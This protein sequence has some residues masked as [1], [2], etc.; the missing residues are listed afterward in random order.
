M[1]YLLWASIFAAQGTNEISGYSF[2]QMIFYYLIVSFVGRIIRGAENFEVSTDIYEGTLTR[3]LLFPHNYLQFKY[4]NHLA[5]TSIGLVQAATVLIILQFVYPQVLESMH[6]EWVYWPLY[7]MAIFIASLFYFLLMTLLE[8][9]AFWADNVWSL[10]VMARFTIS[11]FGGF[12]L[13]LTLF[14]EVLQD[15]LK[16]T[17]F[18]ALTYIPVRFLMGELVVTEL[19][20][21]LVV[22]LIWIAIVGLLMSFVWSKGR[23]RF[24]GVGQ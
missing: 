4:A 1:A 16:Y 3:Y 14:P 11:F 22:L 20:M 18:T 24:S 23:L 7:I 6:M 15:L 2:K 17:P 19:L 13:P 12:Y 5:Y 9:F 10:M 8:M 21:A